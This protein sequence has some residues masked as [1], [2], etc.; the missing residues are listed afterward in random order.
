MVTYKCA[1]IKY[2]DETMTALVFNRRLRISTSTALYLTATITTANWT[3][4]DGTTSKNVDIA[5]GAANYTFDFKYTLAMPTVSGKYSID[6]TFKYYS[7]AARTVLISTDYHTFE[8]HF[9]HSADFSTHVYDHA[10]LDGTLISDK[11]YITLTLEGVAAGSWVTAIIEGTGSRRMFHNPIKEEWIRVAGI[12]AGR[13]FIIA[14][15]N[16]AAVDTFV[17]EVNGSNQGINSALA[18]RKAVFYFE[19][20]GALR[21]GVSLGADG[22]TKV[23]GVYVFNPIP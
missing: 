18:V 9:Y 3:W 20:A 19:S 6:V 5:A 22:D 2:P 8:L 11:G 12:G 1:N 21:V 23:D 13:F 7:D 4:A 10:S 15:G 17:F 14:Y 16:L